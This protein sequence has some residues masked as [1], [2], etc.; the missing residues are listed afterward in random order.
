[1]LSDKEY[2]NLK[3]D[4]WIAGC[5]VMLEDIMSV[6]KYKRSEHSKDRKKIDIDSINKAVNIL[7]SFISDQL[8]SESEDIRKM[9]PALKTKLKEYKQF[10]NDFNKI[11]RR[12]GHQSDRNFWIES[13][14]IRLF[15]IGLKI[16][17]RRVEFIYRL[18]NDYDFDGIHTAKES[19]ETP[20]NVLDKF[21][22]ANMKRSIRLIDSKATDEYINN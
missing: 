8:L 4:E 3:S 19:A 6:S 1:M 13:I 5:I 17:A 10:Q 9:I 21:D 7:E 12:V 2:S 14:C 16:Q 11:Q 18:F 15:D 22:E 20:D